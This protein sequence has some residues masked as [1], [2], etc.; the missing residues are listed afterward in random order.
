MHTQNYNKIAA[1]IDAEIAVNRDRPSVDTDDILKN[2]IRSLADYFKQDNPNFNRQMFYEAAGL[3][4]DR[5]KPLTAL[6][7][8]QLK[9][10][11]RHEN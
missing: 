1:I 10:L 5:N 4:R 9:A 8:K 7:E 3:W 11:A 6:S 2:V